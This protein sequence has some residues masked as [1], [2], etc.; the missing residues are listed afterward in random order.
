MWAQFTVGIFLGLHGLVHLL[1]VTPP[2][3][4]V[5]AEAF[6]T[7]TTCWL[8]T[9]AG[10][11]ATV[12]LKLGKTLMTLATVGLILSSIA[13]SCSQSW[14]TIPA[15][16]AAGVSLAFIFL[17]W[18]IGMVGGALIDIGIIVLALLW[19]P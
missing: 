16:A 5:E 3:K 2:E 14:W 4:A 13:L 10:I 15:M 18:K 1:Y 12:A 7:F 8:V 9:K 11:K 17:Y 6:D 19:T